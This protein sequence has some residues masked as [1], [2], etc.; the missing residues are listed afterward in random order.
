[1]SLSGIEE[2]YLIIAA[3]DNGLS[4]EVETLFNEVSYTS[5]S[6]TTIKEFL[7]GMTLDNDI[8][9]IDFT[10]SSDSIYSILISN[11]GAKPNSI[12]KEE[13]D[14]KLEILGSTNTPETIKQLLRLR[15]RNRKQRKTRKSNKTRK[16]KKSRR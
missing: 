2:F 15:S 7:S 5:N 3:K 13:F 1:M 12:G 8:P 6:S 14:R 16:S 11:F 4:Q 10:G 9:S